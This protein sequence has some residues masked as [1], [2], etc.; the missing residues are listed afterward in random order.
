[1]TPAQARARED[2]RKAKRRGL[3]K[4]CAWTFKV[5]GEPHD[6]V[7][8]GDPCRRWYDPLPEPEHRPTDPK[9]YAASGIGLLYGEGNQALAYELAGWTVR[10]HGEFTDREVNDEELL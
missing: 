2:E 7:F 10:R 3:E 5:R 6:C 1:M 8:E 9:D 4:N